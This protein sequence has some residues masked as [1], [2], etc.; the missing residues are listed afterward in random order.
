MLL[1]NS[2]SQYAGFL[3]EWL[4]HLQDYKVNT[5][6]Q[7]AVMVVDMNNGFCNQGALASPR[8]NAVISPIVSL[9][10]KAWAGGVREFY[11]LNDTHE[12]DAVEFAAF[13]P[14][15]VRGTA[16]SLPV[17]EIRNLEFFDL[18]HSVEKNSI[19]STQETGLLSKLQARP[20]LK[21][22]II[23]GNCTD[24]CVYQ[25]AMALRLDANARQVKERRII[26]PADCVATY[27]TPVELAKELG[28]APHPGD[29][30]HA[31]FLHHMALNAVDVVKQVVL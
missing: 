21:E 6:E 24:L 22:F 7:T 4:E 23:V 15:C 19:S 10:R 9:L 27:D 1:K 18:M 14:H 25:L 11:L 2:A 16:E 5:P 26:I 13:P 3:E 12:P 28:A 31:V 8:V 29:I 17:Q 30:I 20:G